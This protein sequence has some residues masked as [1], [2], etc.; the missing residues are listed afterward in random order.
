[1]PDKSADHEP[2]SDAATALAAFALR[3]AL[4]SIEASGGPLIPFTVTQSG[5]ARDL[6][7][8][9]ADDL[10]DAMRV[11]NQEAEQAPHGDVA[12]VAWDGFITASGER[13]DAVFL[14]VGERGASASLV[15][16][17]RYDLANHAQVVGEIQFAYSDVPLLQGGG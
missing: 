12:T 5:T 6:R 9:V 7:R 10:E 14:R 11:A 4:E 13:M 2:L 3:H 17:Q 16:I 15:F 8:F 1:V